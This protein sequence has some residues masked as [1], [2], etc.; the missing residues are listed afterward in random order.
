MS[1]KAD[2]DEFYTKYPLEVHDFP[3]RFKKI[4]EI[5]SGSLLDAGCGTGT[6]SKYYKGEYLGVDLSE[7]AIQK[8]CE[9]RRKDANFQ[10]ADITKLLDLRNEIF[11][12]I[13]LGEM[14]EHVREDDNIFHN[15]EKH[16]RIGTKWIITV[17]NANRVPDPD[18]VR[19]FTIP[20]LREKLSKFGTVRFYNWE[21]AFARI[22]CSVEVGVFKEPKIGLAMMV[23]NEERGIERAVL[24][25]L[26]LVDEI[27]I[28]VDTKTTDNT[29][30]LAR[31]YADVYKEHKFKDDFSKARNS[32]HAGMKSEW[33]FFIDG[34]E[35]VQPHPDVRE[36]L[37]KEKDGYMIKV[38]MESGGSFFYPRLYR[39][40]IQFKNRIHNLIQTKNVELLPELTIIHDRDNGLAPSQR[41]ARAK[42]RSRMMPWIFTWNLLKNPSDLRSRYYLARYYQDAKKWHVAMRHYT[43]YLEKTSNPTEAYQAAYQAHMCALATE[44]YAKALEFLD[45]CELAAPMRWETYKRKGMIYIEKQNWPQAI[46]NLEASLKESPQIG[47]DS[48]EPKQEAHTRERLGFA[49]YQ[50]GD[51]LQAKKHWQDALE[52]KPP[53]GIVAL[54]EKRIS[55]INALRPAQK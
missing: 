45:F 46:I 49:Y 41:E 55:F 40:G 14:L 50:V 26:E 6:L 10:V 25:A 48:P 11:D 35:Y 23:W 15:L 19:E 13:V 29:R 5:A 47:F 12:T 27:H 51:F 24:S 42:Q 17:P 28:S 22:M 1:T 33:I 2:V 32:T 53:K 34:H 8:A 39:N 38:I 16:S 9:N 30:A 54:L 4:S 18:H 3:A 21:G 43:I 36:K 31:L 20:V 37:S 7:V 44:N 52:H